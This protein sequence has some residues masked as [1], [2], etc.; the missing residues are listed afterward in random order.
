MRIRY[1]KGPQYPVCAPPKPEGRPNYYPQ[2][3]DAR[4]AEV[5][6]LRSHEIDAKPKKEIT[7]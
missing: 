7:R 3:V 2:D 4:A 6:H 1:L 5:R